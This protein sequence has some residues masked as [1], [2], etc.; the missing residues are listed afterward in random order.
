MGFYRRIKLLPGVTLNLSRGGVSTSVGA[1]EAHFTAGHGKARTTVGL[2]GSGLSYKHIE[3][4]ADNALKVTA[5]TIEVPA[6]ISKG[7]AWRGWLWTLLMIAILATIG[8]SVANADEPPAIPDAYAVKSPEPD[9]RGTSLQPLVIQ[10]P[11]DLEHARNERETA[12]SSIGLAILTGLLFL[13]NLW[14]ISEGRRVSTRQALDTQRAIAEQTRAA[15]EMHAVAEATKNN[16]VLMSGMLQKQMRAYISVEVGTAAFQNQHLRFEAMPTLTNNG[17]TPARNVCFKILSDILD[18]R[19]IQHPLEFAEIGHLIINDMGMAPRQSLT[20][21]RVVANR[22]PDG[23][24]GDIMEGNSRRLFAWGKVTYDDVFGGSW[25]TNFCL[26]YWF[27][28][29]GDEWKVF[30]NFYPKH[31][32]ST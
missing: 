15:D 3:S 12:W 9:R 22:V 16:A 7:N 5:S 21:R 18:G 13:A 30:G 31:N 32:N 27:L 17:L 29:V 10:Q 23:D 20:I 26:S 14:L 11:A 24:V 1:R 19:E 8:Y 28:K 25:E 6:E 2:P 4:A